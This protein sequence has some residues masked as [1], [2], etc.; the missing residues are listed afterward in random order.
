[1]FLSPTQR[2]PRGWRPGSGRNPPQDWP[3][4][5]GLEPSAVK[6]KLA[7]LF[8]HPPL[9]AEGTQHGV[10]GVRLAAIG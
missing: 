3:K 7:K 8:S 2:R 10:C 5:S 6:G 9:E 1:M 4:P